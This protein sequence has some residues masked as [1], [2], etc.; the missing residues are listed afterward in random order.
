[1]DSPPITDCHK[2]RY[3]QLEPGLRLHWHG[4][5]IN[6]HKNDAIVKGKKPPMNIERDLDE[7]TSTDGGG[8]GRQN[9]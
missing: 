5:R 7:D 1:M 6:A 9:L 4:K 3:L 8:R 2:Y